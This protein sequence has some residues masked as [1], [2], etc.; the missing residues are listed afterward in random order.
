MNRA[1]YTELNINVT[2]TPAQSLNTIA[3]GC[4]ATYGT[5]ATV[6][7]GTK[8]LNMFPSILHIV[9]VIAKYGIIYAEKKF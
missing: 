7:L 3:A 4:K 2:L 9:S 1:F 8:S 6:L 5:N